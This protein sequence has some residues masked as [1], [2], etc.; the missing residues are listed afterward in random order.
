MHALQVSAGQ[1]EVAGAEQN[2]HQ[3]VIGYIQLLGLTHPHGIAQRLK[4]FE[5]GLPLKVSHAIRFVGSAT[6]PGNLGAGAFVLRMKPGRSDPGFAG[7]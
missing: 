7:G 6:P 5:T 4:D 3:F 1:A 2:L